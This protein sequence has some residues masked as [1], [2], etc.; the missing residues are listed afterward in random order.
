M[1]VDR[2]GDGNPIDGGRGQTVMAALEKVGGWER[3]YLHFCCRARE[4]E[5][6]L[7]VIFFFLLCCFS[8]LSSNRTKN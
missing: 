4:R 1:R 5:R 3:G 6:G 7:V 2:G 8:L